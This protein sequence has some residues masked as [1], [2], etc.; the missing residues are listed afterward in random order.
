MQ[1]TGH[2]WSG[3]GA[4]GTSL[5]P[6]GDQRAQL[7]LSARRGLAVATG[8]P[9]PPYQRVVCHVLVDRR[10]GLATVAPWILD[11]LADLP[12]RFRLPCHRFR[13][14]MP[15]R[16]SW[17]PRRLVVR[18]LVAG[19]AAHAD[20]PLVVGTA[21]H[22]RGMGMTVVALRRSFA[23]RVAIETARV[24]KDATGLHEQRARAFRR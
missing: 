14:D 24:L 11:L 15:Q 19:R 8:H 22:Q 20:G 10:E 9:S 3:C 17:H 6:R 1:D 7:C 5:N 12:Q 16:M 13:R 21:D 4:G 18:I 23:D 2:R